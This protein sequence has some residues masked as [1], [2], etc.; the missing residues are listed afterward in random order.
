MLRTVYHV[1]GF[2]KTDEITVTTTVK[3]PPPPPG[4][5]IVKPINW[6]SEAKVNKPASFSISA[7]ITGDTTNPGFRI[8]LVSGPGPIV[9]S[10]AGRTV[11][12]NPGYQYIVTV[13]ARSGQWLSLIHI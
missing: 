4:V 13:A 12:I 10:A 9:I 1:L 7:N 11:T 2:V 8:V 5:S 6:P 3:A